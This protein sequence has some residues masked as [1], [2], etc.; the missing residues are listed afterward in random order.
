M[1]RLTPLNLPLYFI[2]FSKLT[3]PKAFL[4]ICLTAIGNIKFSNFEQ[5]KNVFSEIIETFSDIFTVSSF[6]QF[7]NTPTPNSVTLSGI[8]IVVKLNDT[9]IKSVVKLHLLPAEMENIVIKK[10]EFIS[11]SGKLVIEVEDR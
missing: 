7:S 11:D 2:I 4:S 6:L 10:D 8:L 1:L 9:V 3:P 5:F